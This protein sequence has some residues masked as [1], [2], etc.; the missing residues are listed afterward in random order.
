MS[1]TGIFQLLAAV[2]MEEDALGWNMDDATEEEDATAVKMDEVTVDEEEEDA[3]A[4][5]MEKEDATAVKM[6]EDATG[7]KVNMDEAEMEEDRRL[8]LILDN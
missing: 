3:T 1:S 7:V 5:K 6:E 4:V 2:K 8:I